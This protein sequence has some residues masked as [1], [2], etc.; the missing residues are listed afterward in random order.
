LPAPASA[1]AGTGAGAGAGAGTGAG[2]A[3]SAGAEPVSYK[4]K[5]AVIEAL[6]AQDLERAKMAALLAQ[7]SSDALDECQR[8]VAT[9]FAAGRSSLADLPAA[10]AAL[11]LPAAPPS[12][13]LM[14]VVSSAVAVKDGKRLQTVL[15]LDFTQGKWGVAQRTLK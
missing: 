15:V 12:G 7:P 4:R 2:D 10:T 8:A 5:R 1:G 13:K 6:D 11:Q 3:A 14:L 9:A